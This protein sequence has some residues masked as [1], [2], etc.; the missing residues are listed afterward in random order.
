MW[1]WSV[2]NL[3]NKLNFKSVFWW[4][5]AGS[6]ILRIA[7]ITKCDSDQF[8]VSQ[9]MLICDT[10]TAVQRYSPTYTINSR[11]CYYSTSDAQHLNTFI[12]KYIY[13]VYI[14]SSQ[15]NS[16][17]W[18][19]H[20]RW[21]FPL[22]WYFSLF[23]FPITLFILIVSKWTSW[24]S[25]KKYLFQMTLAQPY[26]QLDY[27]YFSLAVQV[28]IIWV[29]QFSF[30]AG[31]NTTYPK[32]SS[33]WCTFSRGWLVLLCQPWVSG[34]CIKYLHHFSAASQTKKMP[35]N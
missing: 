3:Q 31:S 30:C 28:N 24:L 10:G 14:Y 19:I 26:R 6:T 16:F 23:L 15:V 5:N 1:T 22:L 9:L 13:T 17:Q 21:L 7:I 4:P 32:P 8:P 29:V 20:S 35:P 34:I 27:F 2:E 11:L 25:I 18:S 33:I 12:F